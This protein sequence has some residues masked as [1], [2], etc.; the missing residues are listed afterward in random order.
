MAGKKKSGET[1]KAKKRAERGLP[2][3]TAILQ[4]IKDNPDKAGKREIA[5][6][7]G[8]KGSA[9]IDL[10]AMLK[11]LAEEGLIE[12]SGKRIKPAGALPSVAAIDIIGRDRNGGL[13]GRPANPGDYSG[14]PP[15]VE[16][17]P[18]RRDKGPSAGVGSRVLARLRPDDGDGPTYTGSIVKLLER[19]VKAELG[20]LRK[21]GDGFRLMPLTKNQD[22]RIVSS[23]D[24]N[25]AEDGDLVEIEPLRSGRRNHGLKAGRVRQVVGSAITEKA[26]S[27]I[28]IHA[29]GIPHIFPE[30]V[31]KDA[32]AAKPVSLKGKANNV[33]ATHEDWRDLPLITID[34]ADAKDHDDAIHGMPDPEKEGGYIATVAIA[35]VS[36]YVRPGSAMDREALTRG[37]SVYFPDRVVPMLPEKISNELCSLREKED[38]PALAVRMWFDSNGRKTRHRFH[39]ILMR[40]H[41]KLS[42][43]EAQNAT[44]GIT[45]DKTAPI[46]ET[47]IQP[48]WETYHCLKRGRQ[49]RAPLD[50]DLSERKILL[51]QDGTVDRVIV[52]ERLDAHKLVEEFM[53]QANVCAAET[54]EEKKQ[55][56]IFRTHD[57]PSLDKL[58]A[59]REFL[60]GVGLSLAK[61][62]S[63]RAANFNQILHAVEGLDHEELVN[64]VVLR[65]QSQ[66]EYSPENIGHFGLNLTQYAHF[67]SPIRRYA[68]LIVHRALVKVLDLGPGG[69]TPEEEKLLDIIATDVSMTERRAM[70]A[71]RDTKDRLIAAHLSERIGDRFSGRINGV[72][73]AGLF[74]TLADTG[75]DGFVPIS[76]ISEEYYHFDPATHSLIGDQSRLAYQVG[77]EVEVKLVEAAPIAGALR[78]DMLSDGKPLSGLQRSRRSNKPDPRNRR[79]P[80]VR[81]AQRG[82]Y[83]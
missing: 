69:L 80:A 18:Q 9:K 75:A 12:K 36:Y 40:S 64:Q 32:E 55:R 66:A 41:A 62:G 25:G 43:Q 7:F 33:A 54:L 21:A 51:K 14:E 61:S 78:F 65:S 26:A 81:K 45:N 8:I 68:D 63:L 73:R 34:P 39:R 29:N 5:R 74:V 60:K 50:L 2:D 19:E 38:R 83:R 20:I 70:Q 11:E 48:L 53:I 46:A 79:R 15:K 16:L 17:R 27:M 67:T 28:A 56:L 37:N 44:D 13:I 6:A 82:K 23:D 77:Q 76:K 1:R 35:D 42:Y 57:S 31:L 47:I 59:L 3:K 24:L 72:T 49:R 71:E 52:P 10:K 4:F 58:E 30:A 22:E